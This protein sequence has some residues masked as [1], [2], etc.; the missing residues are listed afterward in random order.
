MATLYR[1]YRP[2]RWSEVSGQSHIVTT[3]TNALKGNLL[4]Q[5][6]L[7]TGPRGTGKTTVARL[8]AQSVN[9]TN[10]INLTEPCGKCEN[11]RAF[12]EGRAFDIIEIDGA[13]NNSVENVRE[14]RE[15]VKLSP[16]LG[17]K[18]LYIIDEV[19]MLSTGAWNA[20]LK[21]LE[22]PPAHVIFILATTELHKIPDTILSRCQRFD[23]G[24]LPTDIII[25]KLSR[26]AD[27]EGVTIE[28]DALEMIALA[29]EGGMRDAES[30]LSQVIALED[31]HITGA[32]TASILG[33][34]ERKTVLDFVSALGTRDLDAAIL[35]LESIAIKGADFRSF[36]GA[37]THFTRELLFYKLGQEAKERLASH[38]FTTEHDRLTVIAQQFSFQDLARLMELIHRARKE[39]RHAAIEHVPLE[40]ATLAFL[41]PEDLTTNPS[42]ET[43]K[44]IP[45][46]PSA[47]HTPNNSQDSPDTHTEEAT[48]SKKFP[49]STLPSDQIPVP[50]DPQTTAETPTSTENR[51]TDDGKPT[52]SLAAIQEKW[53][54]FLAEIKQRNAS[55][56]LSLTDTTP[57]SFEENV[58]HVFVRHAFHK[59]RLEKPEN[60]L[61]VEDT[62]ATILGVKARFSIE[63]AQ[64]ESGS[65]DPLL[66][67]ALG[68]LG[69]KVVS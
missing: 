2:G 20:L 39:I 41:Y 6:Y 19:H 64:K 12:T 34:S 35:T 26:I 23:F 37:L 3:L 69:G 67:S 16:T 63:L 29:A 9:C 15:T 68:I 48:A 50:A 8:L 1:K 57:H 60:R 53:P 42:P 22:E 25:E 13:S 52:L 49:H 58:V 59:E 30:L 7:F 66:D 36:A 28:P 55:L 51:A 17:A 44:G 10:R 61:T 4:A 14:L 45:R 21:T 47:P 33:I 11:C 46:T 18:K 27:K 24:S 43:T 40:I 32:E 56:S 62:L 65:N 31:A 54:A 5:A 38:A